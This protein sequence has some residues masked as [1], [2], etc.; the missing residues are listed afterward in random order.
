M[1]LKGESATTLRERALGA[2]DATHFYPAWGRA[3]LESMIRNRPDWCVS[4]QRNWGVP[5]PFFTHKDSGDLH[6]RTPELLEEIAKRVEQGGIEA[7]FS[8]DPKDV[9]GEEAPSY[10]KSPDTLD[11]W[12]DSG[13]THAASC[14]PFL[15]VA[16]LPIL[17][18]RAVAV[19]GPI[20]GIFSNL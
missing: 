7:W 10:R 1:E 18:M 17:A 5:I 6:P 11:V 4:R 16:A 20:P 15:K 12:F 9:L 19:S 2:V 8:L 13:T 3:R 14:R